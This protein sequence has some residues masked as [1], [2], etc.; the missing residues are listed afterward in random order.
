MFN[1]NLDV[2]YLIETRV[3]TDTP[4]TH[5]LT[6]A[7]ARDAVRCLLYGLFTR[8]SA[9]LRRP[10]NIQ[11]VANGTCGA[12]ACARGGT[13]RLQCSDASMR[14]RRS[15]SAARERAMHFD[16]DFNL[17]IRDVCAS[18][19][20]DGSRTYVYI[21]MYCIDCEV[22]GACPYKTG[23]KKIHLL[24]IMFTIARND[25]FNIVSGRLE[26]VCTSAGEHFGIVS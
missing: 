15:R 4:D 10:Q 8:A 7:S 24:I 22:C 26:L 13:V 9:A 20:E 14:R 6:L 25:A 18:R 17:L 11:H 2:F 12:S 19:C 23:E 21:Y 5:V 1:I 16:I 3:H